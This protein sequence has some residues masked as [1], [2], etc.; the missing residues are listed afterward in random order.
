M[1]H[2]GMDDYQPI[3]MQMESISLAPEK[4]FYLLSDFQAVHDFILQP[5][6]EHI[7]TTNIHSL[8]SLFEVSIG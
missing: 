7:N 2:V 3:C 1:G 8:N 4:L 6:S 5:Q